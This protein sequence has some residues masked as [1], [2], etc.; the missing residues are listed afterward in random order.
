MAESHFH[1]SLSALK[2][3]QILIHSL[4]DG[5]VP[6]Q[7]VM[8]GAHHMVGLV[9]YLQAHLQGAAGNYGIGAIG[10]VADDEV[11]RA[12]AFHLQHL[13]DLAGAVA[14]VLALAG[15]AGLYFDGLLA[16]GHRYDLG[17]VLLG[18][19]PHAGFAAAAG[20]YQKAYLCAMEIEEGYG[21][22]DSAGGLG[23]GGSW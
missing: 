14:G 1:D 3:A 19:I 20:T 2:L 5:Q 4:A 13:C 8:Y 12:C 11:L 7:R 22:Y 17:V 10:A 15:R 6:V 9:Y 21:D 23:G 16:E 18:Y